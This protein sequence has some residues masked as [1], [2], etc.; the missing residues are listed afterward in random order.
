METNEE[1]EWE[2]GEEWSVTMTMEISLQVCDEPSWESACEYMRREI[3]SAKY[4][5]RDYDVEFK[6]S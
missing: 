1:G 5:F 3:I 6:F 2:E 4:P